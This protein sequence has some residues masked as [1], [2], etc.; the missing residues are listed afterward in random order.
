MPLET[1]LSKSNQSMESTE[2]TMPVAA[3]MMSYAAWG[4]A[5][6]SLAKRVLSTPP[7]DRTGPLA[8]YENNAEPSARELFQKQRESLRPLERQIGIAMENLKDADASHR[9]FLPLSETVS[10]KLDAKRALLSELTRAE[11][12]HHAQQLRRVSAATT[13]A[14]AVSAWEDF[15][16]SRV[17][18]LHSDLAVR[19][20][21]AVEHALRTERHLP[22]LIH[23][24]VKTAEFADFVDSLANGL[25]NLAGG[26][27]Q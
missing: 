7:G 17:K 14:E 15:S 24:R 2:Q 19:H 16:Q 21:N 18:K 4:T 26:G 27:C 8:F 25:R 13:H 1:S 10:K 5:G 23:S 9:H 11:L 6:E 22:D 3:L 20:V 12:T